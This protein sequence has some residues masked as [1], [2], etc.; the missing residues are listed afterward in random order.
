MIQ[1][2]T[3]VHS[4]SAGESTSH[5]VH[6]LTQFLLV[7]RY[8]KNLVLLSLAVAA[9]L[10]GLYYMTATPYYGTSARLL[11]MRSD[12]T[13]QGASFNTESGRQKNLM[14]TFV[15]LLMSTKVVRGAIGHLRP[16]DCID[17][18]G[19]E[20]EAWPFIIKAHLS[21]EAL[22]GTNIIEAGYRSKDPKAAVAVLNAVVT[23]YR[24]F[25]DET[26][27]GT[28]AEVIRLLT[29]KW[30]E[31]DKK[32]T[33]KG[34]QQTQLRTA[35]GDMTSQ[36]SANVM[37]PTL[38]SALYFRE[39]LNEVQTEEMQL[40]ASLVA[41]RSAIRNGQDLQQHV[42]TLANVVGEE[43]LANALGISRTD[44]YLQAEI[45]RRLLDDH[46]T[47]ARMQEEFGPNHPEVVGLREKI[48][49][50]EYFLAAYP[51]QIS[52]KVAKLQNE[53]LGPKL[54][55]MVQ[56]KL[57]EVWQNETNLQDKYD[58]AAAEAIHV[59]GQL[60][61]LK[62]L[63]RDLE[64]LWTF[65][66]NLLNQ[67]T[68][69]NLKH[70]GQE[71]STEVVH[72]PVVA[73]APVSPNLRRVILMVL[74][75]GLG[76]GLGL[77]YVLDVLD[78]RFRS[79]E[80]MQSQ[81][82][83]PVLTLVRQLETL[84]SSGVEALQVHAAPNAAESEAFRTLRT[85]LELADKEARQ[86]VITS[87]EPGDGKTTVLAN[88]A[89]SY[90]QSDKRTLLIDADLRRPGMTA[91]MEMRG[92][93]GLSGLIRSDDD[94]VRMATAH[95]RPSGVPGLDVLASGPRPTNPAEL[96]A[97]PRFSELLAWAETVYDQVLIDSP[98]ALA[99][100]DAAVIGR[101]VDGAVM[102]VQPDK[103][104][105][106]IVVRAA[107]SLAALKIPLVGIVVNRIGAD[108]DRG[109][110]GYGEGYSYAYNY[111]YGVDG[112]QG[113]ADPVLPEA[114]QEETAQE[115]N[116]HQ[117][118]FADVSLQDAASDEDADAHAGI[119]PRRI[120]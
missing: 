13:N 86:I 66:E 67:I 113:D 87:A 75:G 31:L 2:P 102:V 50:T 37:H 119:V 12:S 17:F 64:F 44:V 79:V 25:L 80:E 91:L 74:V 89:V 36:S 112:E 61:Q 34:E 9:L 28:S 85:G 73:G 29:E 16:E 54:E 96:L 46:A 83:V 42:M 77:V 30:T 78:D 52:I 23:S 99:T 6:A 24:K 51:E 76:V 110:Y 14:P 56:Q 19:A 43:L 93:D 106:R 15:T 47:L 39:K 11:V 103:N 57:N 88:L 33:K 59:N 1:E 114:A 8:R 107:E 53:V 26:H 27:K 60:A 48:R 117:M 97:N 68:N 20:R 71:V 109:Y 58:Q 4:E 38:E 118:D 72:E 69:V 32:I 45:Q 55:Q 100:S 111:S 92:I 98:P 108:G 40:E 5:V 7:V 95:I 116:V 41:I 35:I 82:K 3:I 115:E 90:A 104:R 120:S 21:A 63:S 10:G 101:L 81:L 94:V 70:D 105:R 84:A 49:M 18:A 22:L 62:L 65:H